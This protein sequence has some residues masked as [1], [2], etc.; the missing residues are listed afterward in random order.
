MSEFLE[1][2]FGINHVRC[3]I[4]IVSVLEIQDRGY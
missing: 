3:L 1:E 2:F 4:Q